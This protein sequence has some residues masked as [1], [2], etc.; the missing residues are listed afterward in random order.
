MVGLPVGDVRVTVGGPGGMLSTVQLT[1]P[2]GL[3]LPAASVWVTEYVCV[4]SARL[5][6]VIGLLGQAA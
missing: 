4:P 2:A 3:T 5:L 1:E 6:S